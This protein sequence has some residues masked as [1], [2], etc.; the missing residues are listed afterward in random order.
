MKIFLDTAN[1]EQIKQM[2]ELGIVDGVT[3]NPTLVA[4]EKGKFNNLSELISTICD[5][6]KGPVSVEAISDDAE[7]IVSEAEKFSKISKYIVVKVPMTKEGLKAVKI[8]SGKNIKTNITLIFSANQALLAAKAGADYVSPFIGRLD[9]I[10]HEGMQIIADIHEIFSNYAFNTEIIVA[11]IRH[12]LHVVEAAKIGAGVATIPFDV[13]D[14]MFRHP[15]TDMGIEKFK[16][17]FEKVKEE[18]KI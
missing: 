4:K 16:A 13:L 10:S 18:Y 8:L 12:P 5:I 7:G 17:D 1:I 15:L 11:S 9:D 14:K 2:C 6:V 3:T